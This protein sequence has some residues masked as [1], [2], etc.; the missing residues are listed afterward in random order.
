MAPVKLF[1]VVSWGNAGTHWLGRMLNAHP[2]VFCLHNLRRKAEPGGM[3]QKPLVRFLARRAR[4]PR[5]YMELLRRVARDYRLAGDVH[6]VDLHETA[7]LRRAHGGRIRFAAVTRHPVL[8]VRSHL[9]QHA[10]GRHRPWLGQGGLR[11]SVPD[12]LLPLLADEERLFFVHV[13][14]LVSR[15]P[16]EQAVGPVFCMERL[17]R[18][19]AELDRLLGHLSQGE[20]SFPDHAFDEDWSAPTAR[21]AAPS[22]TRKPEEVFAALEPWQR[23]CFQRLL[24]PGAREAYESLG[25]DLSFLGDAPRGGA[26]AS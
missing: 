6:G 5:P 20:L 13:M 2:E 3:F 16:A 26:Q 12:D 11:R 1:A 25:Y 7:A 19:R 4:G 18:E 15:L 9:Q 10:L 23:T 24:D 17:T 22:A 8:R 21:H 14:R